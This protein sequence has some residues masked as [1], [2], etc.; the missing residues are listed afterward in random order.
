MFL[1]VNM[2]NDPIF[3][4]M[5][6][7]DSIMLYTKLTAPLQCAIYFVCDLFVSL[8]FII[9]ANMYLQR[10]NIDRTVGVWNINSYYF[11]VFYFR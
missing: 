9:I 2:V 4:I 11:Q 10:E 5:L 1:T 7:H 3:S 8:I 6:D